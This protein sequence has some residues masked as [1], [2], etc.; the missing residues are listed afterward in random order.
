[1]FIIMEKDFFVTLFFLLSL[2]A[3]QNR[4]DKMIESMYEYSTPDYIMNFKVPSNMYITKTDVHFI[5]FEGEK[6]TVK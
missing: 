5:Q 4:N 1:M 2:N 3:C 6:K